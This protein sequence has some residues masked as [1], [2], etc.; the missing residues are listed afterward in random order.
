MSPGPV[1]DDLRSGKARTISFPGSMLDSF[2]VGFCLTLAEGVMEAAGLRVGGDVQG[3]EQVEGPGAGGEQ[4]HAGGRPEGK[5]ELLDVRVGRHQHHQ[6]RGRANPAQK[7]HR[8]F[9][10]GDVHISAGEGLRNISSPQLL[11]HLQHWWI[12]L[13]VI[14]IFQT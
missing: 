6:P 9:D 12:F 13:T 10:I 1:L 14:H 4:P 5:E 8:I 11:F 7:N 2:P 3:G